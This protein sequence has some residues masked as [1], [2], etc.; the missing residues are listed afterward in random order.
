MDF[1]L[2][3]FVGWIA[4]ISPAA[5]F[6]GYNSHPKAVSIPE[7]EISKI[8]SLINEVEKCGIRVLTKEMRDN[9]FVK[10]AYRDFLE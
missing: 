5:V 3:T 1:N 4:S 10:K 9:R 7:P 8:I 6:I 2:E